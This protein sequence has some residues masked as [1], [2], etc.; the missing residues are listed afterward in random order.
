VGEPEERS[1]LQV[2]HC[3]DGTGHTQ[4]LAPQP[5]RS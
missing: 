5:R 2:V 3:P 1:C 4:E